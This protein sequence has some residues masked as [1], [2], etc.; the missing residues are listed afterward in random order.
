MMDRLERIFSQRNNLFIGLLCVALLAY[1]YKIFTFSLGIDEEYEANEP[2]MVLA[3]LGQGRWGMAVLNGLFLR[4]PV[5][6]VVS[7]ALAVAGLAGG[8]YLFLRS[9]IAK[10]H[11]LFM[12][13]A[14]GLTFPT[15]PF[16]L[17]FSTI[18]YGIGAG[19]ICIGLF[20]L[21]S[22][23]QKPTCF[24]LAAS[25]GAFAIAIYQPF[26]VCLPIVAIF[27]VFKAADNLPAKAVWRL[28]ARLVCCTI[29]AMLVYIAL[30]WALR[31]MMHTKLAYVQTQFDLDGLFAQLHQRIYE[32]WK[33][34]VNVFTLSKTL[35]GFRPFVV[36]VTF[37][38]SL[39]WLIWV[40]V[41]RGPLSARIVKLLCL[42]ALP[43][44]LTAIEATMIYDV[45]LR[46][47]VY[48]SFLVAALVALAADTVPYRAGSIFLLLIAATLLAQVTVTN[49]LF[50][51][52][53][54]TYEQDRDLARQIIARIEAQ[55]EFDPST[56]EI[57]LEAAGNWH[58]RPS[59]LAG[60]RGLFDDAVGASFFEWDLGNRRRMAF[61][62]GLNGMPQLFGANYD[63][64]RAQGQLGALA[65][66]VKSMPAW[67]AAGSVRMFN[68][69]IAVVKF[70]DYSPPQALELCDAGQHTY[71][72]P[73][74]T[75]PP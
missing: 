31:G 66:M 7:T 44:L 73:G 2:N 14:V 34:V 19:A 11:A 71:C 74:Y 48:V 40:A 26:L 41:W 18:A 17:A 27:I 24:L 46:S 54:L 67:P 33:R 50:L 53:D 42:L 59:A 22:S 39:A 13:V 5:M 55:P 56:P 64:L 1:G 52:A 62:M 6:P 15:F 61:F 49:K 65:E 25:A 23:Q 72:P 16:I 69:I 10:S 3:W 35:F 51:S 68:K 60:K 70:G 20:A 38:L 12:G 21:W 45:P 32:S 28:C 75:P 29:A 37:S 63:R 57:Q 30:D 47:M 43:I 58:W 4:Q 36:T 8:I 9:L